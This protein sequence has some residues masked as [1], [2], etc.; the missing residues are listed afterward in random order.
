MATTDI[1]AKTAKG[2]T[3]V[4][5]QSASISIKQRSLLVMIDGK[6]TEADYLQR[7]KLMGDVKGLLDEL[8]Q[9]GYIERRPATVPKK[10]DTATEVL[11]VEARNYMAQFMYGMMGPEGDS[12]VLR[13]ERC[14]NN[15]EMSEILT[16]C[17][18]TISKIGKPENA[19]LFCQKVKN[20]IG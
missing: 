17:F 11:N 1:L 3:E 13:I 10:Q 2:E 15:K 9:R 19:D 14:R 6:L 8:E 18:E 12:L 5:G 7:A 16:L 4:A 20:M